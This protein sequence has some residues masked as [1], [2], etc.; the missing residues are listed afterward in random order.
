VQLSTA[1][2]SCEYTLPAKDGKSGFESCWGELARVKPHIFD[3]Y[4]GTRLKQG[5]AN[6]FDQMI[7]EGKVSLFDI[8]RECITGPYAKR[9][10]VQIEHTRSKTEYIDPELRAV[11]EKVEYPLHFIDFETCAPAVPPYAGLRPGEQIAFQW[12]CHTLHAPGED[13]QHS[14]WLNTSHSFPNFRFVESL[15]KQLGKKGTILVWS[16]HEKN[17][18]CSIR[19]QLD[20]FGNDNTTLAKW[21]ESVCGNGED[22]PG[23]LLDMCLLTAHYYFH[24]SMEGSTSIKEVLP[25]VWGANDELRRASWCRQYERSSNGELL[26]PYSTLEPIAVDGSEVVVREGTGAIRAYQLLTYGG[27][28]VS[29][30]AK[31]AWGALLKQYCSLDTLA[32]VIIWRHWCMRLGCS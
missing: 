9:Q 3:L 10:L 1:C 13:P 26:N 25:A 29:R 32:M 31:E 8:P 4:Q 18:L 27:A 24:P 19:E 6:L 23:R 17:I 12:S 2:R 5:G 28:G 30:E 15:A 22:D 20:L 7:A 11:L 16:G 14:E 21:I